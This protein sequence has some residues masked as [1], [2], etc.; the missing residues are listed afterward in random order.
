MRLENHAIPSEGGDICALRYIPDGAPKEI[1]LIYA[2]GFTAGK[3]TFDGLAGYLAGKGY[4]GLT[5]DFVGHKLGGTGGELLR[6]TQIVENLQAVL[7]WHRSHTTAKRIA[8][9]GH[10]MGAVAVMGAAIRDAQS[11]AS[12]PLA[13]T[14]CLCMGVNPEIGFQSVVGRSMQAQRADYVRGAPVAEL[15][16][17]LGALLP[18]SRELGSLP[19]LFVAAQQDVL[20]SV[21]RVERLAEVAGANTSVVRIESSH[22]EAPDKSKMA[23]LKWLETL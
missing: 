23:L 6:M 17:Q 1:A 13:G 15:S 14:A 19:A 11:P 9:V 22:Q 12:P 20:F 7:A 18:T 8:L 4:E 2:H 21:E 10:S 5:F 16:A 3:Y